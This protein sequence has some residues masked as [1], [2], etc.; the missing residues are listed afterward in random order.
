L[1]LIKRSRPGA[2]PLAGSWH[3]QGR[4]GST[5]LMTQGCGSAILDPQSRRT[6]LVQ[7]KQRRCRVRLLL[8]VLA[9]L[10]APLASAQDSFAPDRHF[11]LDDPANLDPGAAEQA[12]AQVADDMA[13]RFAS[14]GEPAAKAYHRWWRANRSPY[15]SNVHG[16]RYVNH[17]V[18]HQ[19]RGY[20]TLKPGEAMPVGSIIAKDSVSVDASGT[21]LPASLALMEKMPKGF[22]PDARDWRYV[23]ILP[24]GSIF[25]DSA[26][27][28]PGGTT[29]CVTC[30]KIAGEEADH[31]F[32][33]PAN[34]ARTP[35]VP[36]RE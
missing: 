14:S 26:G 33:V 28:N 13:A 30:H 22:D 12:Y 10:L 27:S 7:S 36:A 5:R 8:L 9:M 24:D 29:F 23:L 19:A 34:L 18:N 11:P 25:A 35:L 31:L 3:G 17:Y 21:V 6:A 32:L 16:N 2:S 15:L 20:G 4:I 1:I